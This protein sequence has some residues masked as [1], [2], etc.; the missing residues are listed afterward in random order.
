MAGP[1]AD[2]EAAGRTKLVSAAGHEAT[3]LTPEQLTAWRQATAGGEQAW[4]ESVRKVG[5][6][7]KAVMDGLKASLVKFKAAL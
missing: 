5:Q 4:A 6:D 3:K 7:P 2:M 1:W